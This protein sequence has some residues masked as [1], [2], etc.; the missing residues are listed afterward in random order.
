MEHRDL[1][2]NAPK[3]EGAEEAIAL[4]EQLLRMQGEQLP[5]MKKQ[6]RSYRIIAGALAVFLVAIFVMAAA[7]LP[8]AADVME[9]MA[10]VSE[11][12]AATDWYE[13]GQSITRFAS[14]S[15]SNMVLLNVKMSSLDVETLNASIRELD[16]VVRQIAAF[17]GI[18]RE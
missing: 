2:Q 6:L 10:Q 3:S 17:F 18:S 1:Q 15:E 12:L 13:V 9:D 16:Q 4:E 14:M 7:V 8:R 5:V 11:E